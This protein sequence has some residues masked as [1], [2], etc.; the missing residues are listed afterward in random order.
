MLP[1]LTERFA[2]P[3]GVHRRRPRRPPGHRRGPRR[4]GRRPR[5]PPGRGRVHR[6]RHRG[7]QPR[8]PRR[9]A[10]PRRASRCAAPSSTTPCSTRSSASA[11]GSSASTPP[12]A[13]TST[14]SPPR[15]TP[16]STRRVGDGGQQRGRHDPAARPRWP[17]SSATARPAPCCT[18]TRC[19]PFAWLDVA[20][21][22]RRRRPASRQRPQVRRPEGRRRARRARA[23]STLEPLSSAAVRS[24]SGAAARTTSPASSA[25][26]AA[27]AVTDAE[28]AGDGRRAS[29]ALRDRLVDGLL[30]AVP[31]ACAR[32]CP[33]S[34]EGRRHRPT[35]A[36][37]AS[38]ARRC[39]SCSTEAGVCASAASS[40]A[41]G[42]MEPSHVLA[43]MGVPA[44][45]AAGALRL[46]LGWSTTDADVD[47]ARSTRR[48]PAAVRASS[49]RHDRAACRC[50]SPCPAA[51]T[52]R[53]RPRC[54]VEEGHDVVG[55]TMKLW[56]GESDTGCC[57]VADVDDAR[58]V[59]QQLDIDHL[60]FNFGDDFDAHVVDA[61]RRRPRRRAHAEPVH[62]VQPPPQVRPAAARGPSGSASTRSPPVTTPASSRRRRRCGG[63]RRGAD[64]GQGPELRAP[65]A[66]PGRA[67]PGPA[68]R[69]ATS[70]KA[71]V[72][73]LAAEL[74]LRTAD[75]PDSQDV[76]FI[77]SGG[78][79]ER[80]PRRAHPAHAGPW[81][82]TPAGAAVGTSTRSSWSRS[83]SARASAWPAAA[84]AAT[85]STSTC[86]RPRSP[87]ASAAE[88]LDRRVAG[89]ATSRGRRSPVAGP[90]LVQCSAHGRGAARRV[91][92]RRRRCAW[93]RAA[94]A[95]RAGPERRALRR[96]TSSCSAAASLAE[97]RV[98]GPTRLRAKAQ[99]NSTDSR[100]SWRRRGR[101]GARPRR[102]A[103]RAGSG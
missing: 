94:A 29:A 6:R 1:F 45:L 99:Q 71:E 36:S 98:A 82:S 100:I 23:A 62:R 9:G 77:T 69:S 89:R 15:S 78:G 14:R 3:S 72:R 70:T 28:R 27:L 5:V 64:R 101:R 17:S 85:S 41:S 88:L 84:S 63:S 66:R 91:G 55:V 19:R 40:C 38:R 34:R 57:S 74:G 90:V 54:C 96:P 20:A 24:A 52:R 87:S 73:A 60:V 76:C 86:P 68:S 37:T 26:A 35:S 65:H 58:R 61:V 18:P 102:A 43:A 67:G 46:S 12:V 22:A 75:K 31:T 11:A 95:R 51:S 8:R 42:A 4:R 59:A 56:G 93:A 21:D 48:S 44:E 13:S 92:R 103:A 39:C 49:R 50:S 32:P 83:A 53:S 2:N 7:R 10:P 47:R 97:S 80:V 16:T 30:A 33:R 81:W 79:R 25:M